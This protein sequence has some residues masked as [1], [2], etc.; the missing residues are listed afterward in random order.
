MYS[1]HDAM[2]LGLSLIT[3]ANIFPDEVSRKLYVERFFIFL[4]FTLGLQI[5]FSLSFFYSSSS[6]NRAF[7]LLKSYYILVHFPFSSLRLCC[8]FKIVLMVKG[9]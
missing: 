5:K 2:I 1:Q 3:C 6:K 7:S 9:L 4:I 8:K